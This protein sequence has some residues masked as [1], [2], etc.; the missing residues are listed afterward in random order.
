MEVRSSLGG[1]VN[2]RMS[3]SAR[4]ILISIAVLITLGVILDRIYRGQYT[5]KIFLCGL[6]I[7]VFIGMIHAIGLRFSLAQTMVIYLAASIQVG[8][9]VLTFKHE[10]D[11][12]WMAPLF[13]LSLFFPSFFLGIACWLLTPIEPPVTP[14]DHTDD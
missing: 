2:T 12:D 10:N 4:L 13:L 8:L 3:K 14:N 6:P 7:C 9:L 1:V 11:H 5:E